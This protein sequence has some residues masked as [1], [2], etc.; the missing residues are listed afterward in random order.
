MLFKATN[1]SLELRAAHPEVRALAN[2]LDAQMKK[3]GLGDLVVTDV[4]REP[5]FYPDGRWSWHLCSAAMDIRTKGMSAQDVA[6][7]VAF[8]QGLAFRLGVK[9]DVVN[10][11]NAVKGAHVHVEVEDHEWRR[12]YEQQI[13]RRPGVT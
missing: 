6:R 8:L 5:G 1:V 10:E 2:D 4:L 9:V 13:G 11:P 3:W 7:I 12:N